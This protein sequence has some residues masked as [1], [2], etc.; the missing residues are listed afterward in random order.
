MEVFDL[1]PEQEKAFKK[2]KSVVKECYKLKIGFVNILDRTYAY[3]KDMI[4]H[5]DVDANYELP[6]IQYGYP[7]NVIDTIGGCS[8]ADDQGMH[9]IQLTSKGRKVF[10]KENGI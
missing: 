3:N 7:P 8:F 4:N 5:L 9:S 1:T 2:L 6:C 10:N